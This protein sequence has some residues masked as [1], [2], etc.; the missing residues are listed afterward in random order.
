MYL[1]ILDL[2]T[3]S[4]LGPLL[5]RKAALAECAKKPQEDQQACQTYAAEAVKQQAANKAKACKCNF[6]GGAWNKDRSEARGTHN[7]MHAAC[8]HEDRDRARLSALL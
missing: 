6:T 4:I 5:A 2:R 1:P 3:G 8:L 7:E